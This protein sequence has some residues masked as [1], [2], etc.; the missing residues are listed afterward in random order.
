MAAAFAAFALYDLQSGV[1]TRST[2]LLIM[3]DLIE[4]V[5]AAWG[6][7]YAFGGVPQ[8]D[9]VKALA[10]YVFFAVFLAPLT[11]AFIGA[12]ASNG[13]Y[14]TNWRISFFSEALAFLTLLPAIL[15]WVHKRALWARES[16]A[17]H[18]EEGAL[19]IS[20]V[21]LGYFT[22]VSPSGIIAPALPFV[23]LLLWAAL[24]FGA[25]GVSTAMVVLVF[26]SIWGAINGRGPFV[27][28]GP[29]KSVIPLQVFL[30]F[31]AAPFMLLAALVEERKQAE[32]TRSRL[33]SIVE[34]SNDGIISKNLDGIIVSWNR[35]AER[36]FGFSEAEAVGQPIAL[37]VPPELREEEKT[38][39][40][41][42]R[43]GET[44]EHY[45]TVR[46]TKEGK[47]IYVSLTISPLRDPTGRIVG[48]SKIARDITEQTRARE[49]LKKSEERFS[50]AFR[51]SPMALSLVSAKTHRFLDINETYERIWGYT[52]S[53]VIG[54]DALELGLWVNP[55]ERDR[56]N[57][58]L[59]REGFLREAECEWRTKDGRI[60][61]ALA[62]VEFI[63]IEGEPCFLAVVS[64]I[65]DRKRA[66]HAL[67]ES[68]KRFRLMAN[69]APVM[70][71]TSDLDKL[72]DYFNQSWLEF[73]G[74]PLVAEIGNGWAEG[75]HPQDLKACL[76]TYEE[77]FDARRPFEMK[78]RLRRHDGE[79]RWISDTGVP[80]FGGGSSFAGYVG[81][82]I[83][84]TDSKVAEEALSTIGR[85]LMEAQE[86][87]RSRIARELHDDINQR[88]AL[89]ANG[90]QEFE[91]ATSANNNTL[92]DE[93]LQKL[94]QLTN[95][96]ATD[97]QHISHQLHPS[98][99][100]YLGLAATVRDLCHEVS[101]Q[102]KIDVECV[103]RD[104]PENLERNKSLNLFRVVQE[105]L[106]NVVKHSN[107]RHVKVELTCQ[108][109]VVLLR[110]SDDGIGF[111]PEEGRYKHGL[112]LVSMRERM[113]SADGEFAIWSKSSLGTQVEGRVP[114]I[115]KVVG[116]ADE[117][118]AD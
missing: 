63:E 51:H 45:E 21:L 86:E 85:R 107:A 16:L 65:T 38:I 7:S 62:S 87:E 111:D 41:K 110:V 60:L 113:R 30:L 47:K 53:D 1:A 72:C 77:A 118:A 13:S 98:K 66:E 104:L 67:L 68:E 96:I 24:R 9:S 19:F 97:I 10:K 64:D 3:S 36:I 34:C 20:L 29:L 102:H 11:A 32:Q 109:K 80:R 48:A 88:M 73:T 14:W 75:V 35:G 25:T 5:T 69:N 49:E 84:I 22:F 44:V 12:L 2:A 83:D 31:A 74:R 6:L 23:P 89:L 52:R 57:L 39:L 61:I 26:L 76:D 46:L 56:Q 90:L 91:Q 79:Y 93:T 114:A 100:H 27:D 115:R 37:L 92:G 117:T 99:L 70:I 59:D 40:E 106:R 101:V 33:A 116:R 94:W 105:S 55:A 108:S 103:V 28:A 4:V 17:Y 15:G 71:W 81:S 43:V 58:K 54:K 50:K 18:L 95:E 78:Y 112:G 42:A 82:C 8:L